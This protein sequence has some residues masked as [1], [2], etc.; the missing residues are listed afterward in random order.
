[1]RILRSAS[2]EFSD[3]L[4]VHNESICEEGYQWL[5]SLIYTGEESYENDVR[6]VREGGFDNAEEIIRKLKRRHLNN[7]K[8]IS[9]FGLYE[10]YV[11][12]ELYKIGKADLERITKSTGLPTRLHQ[13]VINNK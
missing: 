10:I 2:Q 9:H 13:Q 8:A 5:Q 7:N 4:L 11:N 6:F 3:R 12:G 1:V